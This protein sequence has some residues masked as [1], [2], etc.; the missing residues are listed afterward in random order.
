MNHYT[1]AFQLL[2]NHN[3]KKRGVVLPR[4]YSAQILNKDPIILKLV[5]L[6][7]ADHIKIIIEEKHLGV[8]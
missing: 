5:L 3:S 6:K 1:F 8:D 4:T 2:V 7:M